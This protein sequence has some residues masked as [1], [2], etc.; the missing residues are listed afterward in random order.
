M[1]FRNAVKRMVR[2]GAKNETQREER[3]AFKAESEALMDELYDAMDDDVRFYCFFSNRV[4]FSFFLY[5]LFF[6][7]AA[8]LNCMLAID[9][10]PFQSK[11]SSGI[12][13]SPLKH[14]L[15]VLIGIVSV[16]RFQ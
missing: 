13:I 16:R 8:I 1:N 12:F 9:K 10:N 11:D 3:F 14:F 5:K 6:I 4:A 7:V 15:W 2:R